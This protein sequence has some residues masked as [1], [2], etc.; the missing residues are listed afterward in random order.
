MG[1]GVVVLFIGTI[2]LSLIKKFPKPKVARLWPRK[3]SHN[4]KLFRIFVLLSTAQMAVGATVMEVMTLLFIGDESVLGVLKSSLAI[5]MGVLT[6]VVGRKMKPK[7]RFALLS[8][9]VLPLLL[10]AV[11]LSINFSQLTLMAYI[12]A[13][14]LFGN[15]FWFVYIPIMSQATWMQKDGK[16]EDNYAYIL[17]HEFFINLGRISSMLFILFAFNQWDKNTSLTAVVVGGA[18]LQALGLLAARKLLRLQTLASS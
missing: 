1:F 7:D 8:W 18:V 15:L 13:M 6:Y 11:L 12:V 2:F 9:G 17:D 16:L 10:A 3:I 14:I 5:V 4:W